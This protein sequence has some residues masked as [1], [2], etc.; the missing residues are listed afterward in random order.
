[1]FFLDVTN[2]HSVS[3]VLT[4]KEL[5]QWLKA[6]LAVV[7][8][9]A[10]GKRNLSRHFLPVHCTKALQELFPRAVLK[11]AIRIRARTSLAKDFRAGRQVFIRRGR[12]NTG[13]RTVEITTAT[14]RQDDAYAHRL[15]HLGLFR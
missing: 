11:G 1:M 12:G 3:G 5:R 4:T 9:A 10:S 6:E 2:R 8:L 14:E 15:T 7:I 13:N